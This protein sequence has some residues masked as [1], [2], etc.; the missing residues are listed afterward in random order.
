MDKYEDLRNAVLAGYTTEE[1]KALIA[2]LE[3]EQ[4]ECEACKI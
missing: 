2:V 3:G 4:N 1:L